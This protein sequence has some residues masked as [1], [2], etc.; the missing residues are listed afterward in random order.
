MGYI[1]QGR[2][3][4]LEAFAPGQ[5]VCELRKRL[6]A[7]RVVST[8]KRVI[9]GKHRDGESGRDASER[10]ERCRP[11]FREEDRRPASQPEADLVDER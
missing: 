9:D 5:V 10:S 4:S 1:S 2:I 3:S 6:V 7:P 11:D 8:R